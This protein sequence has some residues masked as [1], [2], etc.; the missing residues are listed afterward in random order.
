MSPVLLLKRPA[1][2]HGHSASELRPVE[3]DHFPAL[4]KAV[5]P[6]LIEVVPSA[7]PNFP[8]GHRPSHWLSAVRALTI[9]KRPLEQRPRH[10]SL[11]LFPVPL[12]KRP[13]EHSSVHWL[14]SVAPVV[15]PN[16]PAA[17]ALHW[18]SPLLPLLGS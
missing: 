16:R 9:L 4:Q 18:L 8:L 2:H 10:W 1:R 5:H 7:V 11:E 3:L 17:Q 6:V 13:G 14:A 15:G 12:S